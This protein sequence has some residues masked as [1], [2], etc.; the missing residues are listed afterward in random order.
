MFNGRK[1]FLHYL[2]TT[3]LM[4][5]PLAALAG[6][7]YATVFA[8]PLLRPVLYMAAMGGVI[9]VIA[10]TKNYFVFINP[11]VK[12]STAIAAMSDGNLSQRFESTGKDEMALLT[13]NL[14]RFVA[15][16]YHT[17][18]QVATNARDLQT[19]SHTLIGSAGT[20][21]KSIAQVDLHTTSV[22]TTATRLNGQLAETAESVRTITTH[23]QQLHQHSTTIVNDIERAHAG[24]LRSQENVSSV[25]IATEQMSATVGE[26]ANNAEQ[27]RQRTENAVQSVQSAQN[28][29]DELGAAAAQIDKIIDVIVEIA[30][31]TKLLA[32][33]AT[34]EAARAGEAGKGFAVVAAEV[35]QLAT[36]TN[37][38]TDDIRLKISSMQSSTHNTIAE[39][40]HISGVITSV[41]D[42][43]SSIAASV[44]EQ[45][46]TTRDISNTIGNV[47]TI[48]AEMAALTGRVK[49]KTT[50]LA[51][52]GSTTSH[53]ME[54]VAAV[55]DETVQTSQAIG[56]VINQAVHATQAMLS[57]TTDMQSQS[58]RMDTMSVQQAELVS[59]YR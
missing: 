17:V 44:E 11:I 2:L 53:A 4:V 20:I 29:V 54:R 50:E 38:A 30:E 42:I 16:L 41:D 28:S 31:Q 40:N 8:A 1:R 52:L 34:I 7:L 39:I 57:A 59:R 35:K 10:V 37:S 32:L 56:E 19:H 9:A 47:A 51:Q 15:Q 12:L 6:V 24:A 5:L 46:V 33:N 58:Q 49:Q 25:A 13:A 45:S 55:V 22:S 23:I 21:N 26:I 27:A 43:V 3:Q 48:V 14:N 18:H 36:Q